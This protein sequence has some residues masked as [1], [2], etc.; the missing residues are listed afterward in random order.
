MIDIVK[1]VQQA[2]PSLGTYVVVLRADARALD[3]PER[4]T[5]EAQ[6]WIEANAPGGPPPRVRVLLAP[7]PGA[8]PAERD[9]TVAAFTDARQLAAF[10]TT[11]TGDPLPEAEEP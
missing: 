7:Y 3:G 8:I 1:A 2:D 11:W 10:A 9:V 4:F 5:P 6:A